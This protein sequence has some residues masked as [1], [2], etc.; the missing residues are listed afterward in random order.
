[1]SD[2]MQLPP[3]TR[4]TSQLRE[5][6]FDAGALSLNLI[7][8]VGRR[9]I[10]P[11]ERLDGIE[12][13][14]SWCHGAGVPLHPG[15]DT[16][17]LV[18]ALH[19]LRDSGYDVATAAI[20]GHRPRPAS[21]DL[22]NQRALIEPPPPQLRITAS[23]VPEAGPQLSAPALQSLIARD[24][25]T[26]ISD[27]AV[28]SRLHECDSDTCRMVYLDTEHGKPRKWCSMQRCGNS[29]KAARYRHRTMSA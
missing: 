16:A 21:V 24:L 15:E 14:R 10:S 5:L 1:M 27:A 28:R 8:T 6:R 2:S 7:A 26:L 22:I 25:I 13:L 18:A 23:G 11:I 3:R 9:P 20:H 12:Q 29:A 19:E 4:V 17:E